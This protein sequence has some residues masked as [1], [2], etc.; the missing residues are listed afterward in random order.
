MDDPHFLTLITDAFEKLEELQR[1]RE[2]IEAETM[3]LEQLIAAAANM[4]PDDVRILVMQRME[5]LRELSRFRD[6]GLTEAIRSVL[7]QGSGDWL[8]ATNVRDRL[9]SLGFDFT[10]YSTN[11]LASISTTLRRMKREEVETTTVDGGVAAYRWKRPSLA[12]KVEA[13]RR[14]RLRSGFGQPK[15][16]LSE[17]IQDFEDAAKKK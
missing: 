17:R 9:L 5:M 16:P 2:T 10:A 6:V 8:T 15:R 14:F 13:V 11:P 3:K 1:D 7:R 4:L 12:E